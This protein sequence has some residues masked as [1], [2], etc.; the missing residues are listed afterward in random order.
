MSIKNKREWL[1]AQTEKYVNEL[2][3]HLDSQLIVVEADYDR[4]YKD[5]LASLT[6]GFE[7]YSFEGK[8]TNQ[9]LYQYHVM[10]LSLQMEAKL[11]EL[12]IQHNRLLNDILKQYHKETID[13]QTVLLAEGGA[14][15]LNPSNHLIDFKALEIAAMYPY[16]DYDFT[17]SFRGNSMK[18]G[19][20]LN[21]LLIKKYT[22]GLSVWDLAKELEKKTDLASF[23]TK[24]I[25][26]TE[27]SRVSNASTMVCYK[28]AGI[29]KVKWLDSTEAIKRSKRAKSQVC[30]SCR[31]KATTNG[32]I[33]DLDKVPPL[34]LHPHCRCTTIAYEFSNG[35][36]R[37]SL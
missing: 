20:E 27:A 33:Y 18:I 23:Y 14:Y 28:D 35:E 16:Q 31:E 21:E 22:V 6:A 1:T 3:S 7:K 12:G 4:I 24:R 19:R 29:K 10:Q 5:L 15:G 26:R 8:L 13:F 17:S 9:M 25:A 34:P 2:F 37:D 11:T 32:G 30:T 36:N